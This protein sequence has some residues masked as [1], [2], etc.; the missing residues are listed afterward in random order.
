MDDN[1]RRRRQEQPGSSSSNP[2]HSVHD[3]SA[4]RR[5]YGTG[6]LDRYRPAPLNTSP[7]GPRSM[8]ST[9]SYSGYYQEPAATFSQAMPQSSIA[10]SQDY[11]QDSRQ[12]Q[13]YNTY[14]TSMLYNVPQASAQSGVYDANQQF[15]S[16]QAAGLQMM[17]ADVTGSYFPS[18]PTN[19]A[20]AASLQPQTASSSGSAV[21]QQG[22]SDQRMLQQSYPGNISSMS[23]MAQA[24]APEQVVEE[25][26]YAGPSA[27][28]SAAMGEAYEQ[29]QGALREVFTNIQ[30]GVLQTASESLLGVSEWLL[31][32][33]V[34]LGLTGDEEALHQ[35]R[36]KLWHDF[37]HAWLSLFQ[38]QKDMLESSLPPQRG[39][40]LISEDDLRKM[41][42]EIVQ[43]CNGIERHGLVDYECGVWEE[44][45]ID[46]LEKCLDVYDDGRNEAGPSGSNPSGVSRSS[47]RGSR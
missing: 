26:E 15:P 30:K 45:I 19:T 4:S 17:P 22:H 12:A 47:H 44:L 32:K 16:R 33:V 43:L 24:G 3:P 2:R 8:A 9:A 28:A 11:G 42:Q 23:G 6:G 13:G 27:S 41:G 5:S 29:Y 40:S 20:A 18:E 1:A 37:N 21:Y 25:Q 46:I 36:V 7:P 34:E 14:N 38:K 35:D 10:Y 31:S 39:Q